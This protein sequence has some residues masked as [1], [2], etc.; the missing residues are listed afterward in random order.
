[1]VDIVENADNFPP[2]PLLSKGDKALGGGEDAPANKQAVALA[3]RTANIKKTLDDL[4][5]NLIH[6]IGVLEGQEQLDLVNTER[7]LKWA[8]YIVAGVLTVWDGTQ[9]VGITAGVSED[10]GNALTY[11]EDGKLYVS[12]DINADIV[13][14]YQEAKE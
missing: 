5:G 14:S 7:L 1:M 10:P 13:Q 4:S 12:N 9:W 11:G 8:G 6:L 2:V 3:Q